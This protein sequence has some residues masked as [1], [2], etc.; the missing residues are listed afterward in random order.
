M[1]PPEP[2]NERLF[3]TLTDAQVARVAA[4]GRRRPVARGDVLVEVGS[5][6]VPFFVVLNGELRASDAAETIVVAH[7]P[8]QFRRSQHAHRPQ[9]V[10]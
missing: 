5:Q 6:A 9:V 3:P 4:H 1:T 10:G 7:R 2:P 8:G